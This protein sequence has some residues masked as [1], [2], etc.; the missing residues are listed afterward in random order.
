MWR[1]TPRG[2]LSCDPG[3]TSVRAVG[4]VFD[5][6]RKS[7]SAVVT[8]VE[9]TVIV[10]SDAGTRLAAARR[11]SAH[12]REPG[13]SHLRLSAGK[14]VVVAQNAVVEP[15]SV[16]VTSATAWTH[17]QLIFEYTPLAE[18]AEE[19]NRYNTKPL[20]VEGEALRAFR[21]SAMFR[22]TDPRALVRYV[23]TLPDVAV[24]ETDTAIHI[25]STRQ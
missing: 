23:Q 20:L 11:M 1:K 18:A 17:R 10:E 25:R 5:V 8:V 4:T 6:Y 15:K 2:R 16:N 19:F 13:P 12:R 14:Q 7:S 24:E 3:D 21:I 9:G 22:S